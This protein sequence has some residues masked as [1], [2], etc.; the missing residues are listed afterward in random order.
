MNHTDTMQKTAE[1][2]SEELFLHM[3]MKDD[4][5]LSAEKAFSIFYKRFY[6]YLMQ[7]CISVCKPFKRYGSDLPELIF[8]NTLLKVY[9]KAESFICIEKLTGEDKKELRIKAWLGR[10]AERELYTF[11]KKNSTH[12]N[13]DFKDD[14]SEFE[15]ICFDPEEIPPPPNEKMIK[16]E[17]ALQQLSDRDR[18]I[19][20]TSYLFEKENKTMPREVIK[21]LCDHWGILPDNL[22]QIRSRS[23]HK[24]TNILNNQKITNGDG[25]HTTINGRGENYPRD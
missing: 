21:D 24:L 12:T 3:A 7:L 5:R 6:K 17:A 15:D 14:M 16:L 25:K 11:L 20:M 18:D 9:Q 10:I 19:L 23:I 8:T 1:L 13:L 22:R 2:T 4:D